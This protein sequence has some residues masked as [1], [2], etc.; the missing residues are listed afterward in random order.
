MSDWDTD[1]VSTN[2]ELSDICEEYATLQQRAE[3][4]KNRMEVLAD[5]ILAEFAEAAGE[6]TLQ[7]GNKFAVTVNRP[8]RWMWD[9]DILTDLFPTEDEI[10][11]HVN[12][13]MTVDKRKFQGLDDDD[14][15]LLLPALTRKP[16][17]AK[18]TV[19][20]NS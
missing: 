8:E 1:N 12:K 7:V 4:I 18:I 15:R 13:R 19:T 11:P 16:G 20:E 10:P 9:N 17:A 3:S 2:S 5:K 14:K 6:Q